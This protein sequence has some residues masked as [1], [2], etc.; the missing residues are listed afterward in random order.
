MT[1]VLLRWLIGC[2]TWN[3]VAISLA[4]HCAKI[5]WPFVGFLSVVCILLTCTYKLSLS[6][7]T[8]RRCC[9]SKSFF[10]WNHCQLMRHMSRH[11]GSTV[12][13]KL[14]PRN[15]CHTTHSDNYCFSFF[16]QTYFPEQTR[17]L[18]CTSRQW[19][20]KMDTH[21]MKTHYSYISIFRWALFTVKGGIHK[22]NNNANRA[23]KHVIGLTH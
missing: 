22:E 12:D 10:M 5:T 9:I 15:S 2:I 3:S 17:K 20:S 14:Q 11:V 18:G 6:T 8:F 23:D 19:F 1:V 7:S 4:S 13:N 21:H 16:K